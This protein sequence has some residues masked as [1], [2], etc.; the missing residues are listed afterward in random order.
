M[1]CLTW[2]IGAITVTRLVESA[3]TGPMGGADSFLAEAYPEVL[4]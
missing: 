1:D 4:K 3:G 2:N